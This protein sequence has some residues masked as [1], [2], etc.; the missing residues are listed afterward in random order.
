MRRSPS[1]RTRVGAAASGPHAHPQHR[2]CPW[3]ARRLRRRGK[4]LRPLPNPGAARRSSRL[5]PPPA[6]RG[7][8]DTSDAS[9]SGTSSTSSHNPSVTHRSASS[10]GSERRVTTQMV[11]SGSSADGVGC[12]VRR[13]DR[14]EGLPRIVAVRRGDVLCPGLEQQRG[15]LLT[16]SARRLNRGGVHVAHLLDVLAQRL[17]ETPRPKRAS[18]MRPPRASARTVDAPAPSCRGYASS[19]ADRS[20]PLQGVFVRRDARCSGR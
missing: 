13:R 3:A 8:T 14:R 17:H 2:R 6:G 11:G 16:G 20:T 4:G 12:G 7:E 10:T 19:V 5:S 15:R 18:T 1:S 9:R